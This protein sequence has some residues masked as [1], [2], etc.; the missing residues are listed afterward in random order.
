MNKLQKLMVLLW[1]AAT[2][3]TLVLMFAVTDAAGRLAYLVA[4]AILSLIL[5]GMAWVFADKKKD[6]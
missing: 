6:P 5:W 2:M 3:A 1:A 4:Y